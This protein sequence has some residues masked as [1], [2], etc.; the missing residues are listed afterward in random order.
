MDKIKSIPKNIFTLH[1]LWPSYRDGR[2]IEE[3][4]K[5]A[6]IDV[7]INEEKLQNEMAI[8]WVSFTSENQQFWNHEYNKHGYCYSE[9]YKLYDPDNFFNMGM[10]LFKSNALDQLMH[11]A[12]NHVVMNSNTLSFTYPE[13]LKI[14]EKAT[15]L[16]FSLDC[17]K[18][19]NKTYLSE[20]RF[21]FDLEMKPIDHQTSSD[22]KNN[23]IY[24]ILE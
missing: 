2:K 7:K 8:Y 4:N 20:I 18:I 15:N 11:R 23:T 10:N 9:R 22:C 17:K 14:F 5:G 3:C 6:L 1:G 12:L 16:K 24:I 13:L 19:N 21:Y